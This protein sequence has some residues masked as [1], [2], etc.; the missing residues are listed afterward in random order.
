MIIPDLY[1][2]IRNFGYFFVIIGLCGFLVLL[3]ELQEIEH[4]FAIW[5]FIGSI[6]L[7]H[8]FIGLGIIFKKKMWFGFFK[9]YLQCMFV[10]YPLGTILSKKILKYIE[11]NNIENFMRR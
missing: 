6:S 3:T 2:P 5:I 7:L 8:I 9:G 10:A 11:Q 4:T 1:K